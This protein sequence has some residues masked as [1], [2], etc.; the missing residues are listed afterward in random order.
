MK[1]LITLIMAIVMML[2]ATAALADL[3]TESPIRVI[4]DAKARIVP[5]GEDVTLTIFGSLQPNTVE[6][7]SREVNLTTQLIEKD[8]GLK[9][10][11]IEAPADGADAK[12]N[13]LLNSGSYPDIIMYKNIKKAAMDQYAQ[14]GIFVALD[15]YISEE[16]TPNTVDLFAYNPA[17]K[18]YVTASD[19]HIYSLPD[20]NE[21]YHCMYGEGRAWYSMPFMAQYEDGEPQTTEELMDYLRWIRD[22]DVNGNGDPNDEVPLA[23]NK[24][25]A[26]RFLRW[27]SNFY[28]VT[29]YENY[30]V[31]VD[32][33]GEVVACFT[34]EEYKMAL[35]Y[36]HSL[37]AEGLIDPEVFTC[38]NDQMLNK[39]C[40][41]EMGIMSAAWSRAGNAYLRYDFA[42]LQP[43]AEVKIILPPT[44]P[45]GE[46]NSV[47]NSPMSAMLA[48]SYQAS[49]EKIEAAMKLFNFASSPFG[50]RVTMYG[51]PGEFFDYDEATQQ[52]LWTS[53][54]NNG[55]SKSGKYEVTDM[56]VY[57]LFNHAGWEAQGDGLIDAPHGQMWKAG[58]AMRFEENVKPNVFVMFKT[59]EYTELFGEVDTYFRTSMLAFIMGEKDIDA[60]WDNYVETYLSMGGEEIRQSQLKAYN[61]A[62]GTNCTF[63]E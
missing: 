4:P 48:V 25:N 59:E 31:D 34:T 18:A 11:F 30:R 14:S 10:E 51:I 21:A 61:E 35:E 9:L 6:T 53:D 60:E 41:G 26:E 20:Y 27:V 24:D 2:S 63:A 40:R 17:T 46:S 15:D 32:S 8:T 5:E 45:D 22:N 62:F 56:Q 39:W 13:L 29:P 49:P 7:Y 16:T 36:A 3:T 19:G 43:D 52:T 37:Y 44:G 33:T 1:R 58:S 47:S 38:S 23:F 28:Q 42:T 57:K 54:L 55:V 12:L 50:W